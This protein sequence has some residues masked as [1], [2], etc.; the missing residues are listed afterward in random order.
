MAKSTAYEAPTIMLFTLLGEG[1]LCDSAATDIDPM[2]EI[3]L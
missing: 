3:E 2:E 1:V